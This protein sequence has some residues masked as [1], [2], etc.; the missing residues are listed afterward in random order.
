MCENK[1]LK[2]VFTFKYLGTLFTA[3]GLHSYD[4]KAKIAR[5]YERCGQLRKIF[6]SPALNIQLKLR[7]YIAGVCSLITFGSETW[8]LSPRELRRL[9]NANSVMLSRIT[10]KSFQEEARACSTS[11]NLVRSIRRRRLKWLGQILRKGESSMAYQ[12]ILDQRMMN[13][14][15]NLTMDAPPHSSMTEL[16]NLAKDKA[17]WTTYV[18]RIR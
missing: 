8:N 1:P 15:G 17:L 5:A 13:R 16:E 4:I 11:F 7:I 12:A 2:N 18:L 6:D 3:D 14:P 9:N 10:G